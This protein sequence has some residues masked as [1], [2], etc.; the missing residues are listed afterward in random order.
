MLSAADVENQTVDQVQNAVP[1]D[2]SK[3]DQSATMDM[4]EQSGGRFAVDHKLHVKF[5]MQSVFNLE[6]SEQANRPIYEDV[7]YVEIMMPGDK[8]NMIQRPAASMRDDRRFPKHYEQFKQGVKEQLVGTPLRLAPFISP[9]LADQLAWFK[10]F[11]IESLR[12]LSDT[13][14]QNFMGAQTLKQKAAEFL[15]RQSSGDELVKKNKELERQIEE[16]RG[17]V[18]KKVDEQ[19]ARKA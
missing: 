8:Q 14:T 11:T 6:K 9:A 15:A 17:L 19:K 4:N 13:A 18:L 2:W 12:D 10:I 1:T 7:E 16:L 3:F 5:Y